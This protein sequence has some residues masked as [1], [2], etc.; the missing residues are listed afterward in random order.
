[1]HRRI[2]GDPSVAAGDGVVLEE[3]VD[4]VL[5]GAGGGLGTRRDGEADALEEGAADGDVPRAVDVDG[6]LHAAILKQ[7]PRQ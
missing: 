1:M 4:G 6:T 3:G 7:A 5:E 2:E